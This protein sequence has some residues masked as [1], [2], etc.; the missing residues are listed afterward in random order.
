MDLR[1]PNSSFFAPSQYNPLRSLAVQHPVNLPVTVHPAIFAKNSPPL[2]LLLYPAFSNLL[3]FSPLPTT[4][5]VLYL[6]CLAHSTHCKEPLAHFR[7]LPTPRSPSSYTTPS[8]SRDDSFPNNSPLAS[9]PHD[10]HC[11]LPA[12]LHGTLLKTARPRTPLTM[13]CEAKYGSQVL[14]CLYKSNMSHSLLLFPP[15]FSFFS[16]SPRLCA[17]PS[18]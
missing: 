18:F 4:G 12:Q 2:S 3:F 7:R 16:S 10:S 8:R 1:V 13:F 11:S 15:L 14:I 5:S 9:S 6:H 17:V